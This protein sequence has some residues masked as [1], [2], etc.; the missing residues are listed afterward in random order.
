VLLEVAGTT[1]T[2]IVF[3]AIMVAGAAIAVVGSRTVRDT[4]D[5]PPPFAGRSGNG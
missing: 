3:S 2:V 4:P 1:P 5:R